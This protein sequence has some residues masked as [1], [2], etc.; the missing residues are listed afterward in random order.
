LHAVKKCELYIS[1]PS[2]ESNIQI[3]MIQTYNARLTCDADVCE[4][5]GIKTNFLKDSS[6]LQDSSRTTTLHRGLSSKG[7]R[8]A[9]LQSSDTEKY[10]GH[11]IVCVS[12][13]LSSWETAFLLCAGHSKDYSEFKLIVRSDSVKEKVEVVKQMDQFK[14]FVAY[15]RY[16]YTYMSTNNQES[17]DS[18]EPLKKIFGRS[19]G[20]DITVYFSHLQSY[21]ELIKYK[22]FN[23][24]DVTLSEEKGE[25]EE[26]KKRI[27][28]Y[29]SARKNKNPNSET[30]TSTSTAKT[31]SEKKVDRELL[32]KD[33][34]KN[35]AWGVRYSPLN[36]DMLTY[37]TGTH[38]KYLYVC[39]M[40]WVKTLIKNLHLASSE[41]IK[42]LSYVEFKFIIG[43]D[44][45]QN[46]KIVPQDLTYFNWNITI[47]LE[48]PLSC[49][50]N[51]GFGN[52]HDT[53]FYYYPYGFYDSGK[54]GRRRIEQC[55]SPE[56]V[57]KGGVTRKRSF[58]GRKSRRTRSKIRGENH[59]S[60][61]TVIQKKK[62]KAVKKV[63]K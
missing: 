1:N 4:G 35:G 57:K 55:V 14:Y 11:N 40:D 32:D 17:D 39:P 34:E 49:Q 37:L 33:V 21:P 46:Q 60:G 18:Y 59:T 43:E 27:E 30:N 45:K 8:K 53:N 51:C 9:L 22:K 26:E 48:E 31:L 12:P 41:E 50:A 36:D 44:S 38:N 25:E 2:I 28:T 56:D 24:N 29:L 52:I 10:K 5:E 6:T 42:Y 16:L 13:Y 58:R 3:S 47:P 15:L 23:A 7:I 19:F 54:L 63:T 62:T 61:Q 20:I